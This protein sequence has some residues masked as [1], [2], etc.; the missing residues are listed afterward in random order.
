M[1]QKQ[2]ASINVSKGLLNV[3]LKTLAAV[4]NATGN[5]LIAGISILPDALVAS[6]LLKSILEEEKEE[7]LKL[8]VP[9]W[10]T[11]QPLFESWQNTCAIIENRLPEILKGVEERL[12]KESSYPPSSTVKQIF[13]EQVAQHLPSWDVQ[14]QDRNMVVGYITPLLLEQSAA[15][16]KPAI[17]ATRE[18]AI[19]KLFATIVDS[20]NKIQNSPTPAPSI[21]SATANPQASGSTIPAPGTAQDAQAISLLL[22]Q[23]R[24]D[25]AY[26][27]YI[28]YDDVDEA[29][30]MNIGEQLKSHGILPW[31]DSDVKPG[32]LIGPQLEEQIEKV[33]AGAV[34]IGDHAIASGQA[35]QMYSFI[36]QFVDRGSSVIPVLLKS[37]PQK[38][39]LPVF[40]ATF[41]WVDFHKEN[42]DPLK[43]LIWGITGTCQ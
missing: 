41:G 8:P 36:G 6:G 35:I 18:E 27:V 2:D 37:A 7:I 10:W 13:L 34:F 1:S 39:K 30:V 42:P 32:K 21:P 5:P 25:N 9:G 3:S 16:L 4:G 29:E 17:D 22:E 40:L 38:P 14:P 24:R 20:L 23:K 11:Q 43:R 15:A 33:S 28:C 26:D 19:A 31:F 12:Q